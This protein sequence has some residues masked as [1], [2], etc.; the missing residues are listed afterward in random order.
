MHQSFI[1]MPHN[2]SRE[3]CVSSLW[4]GKYM[5][6]ELYVKYDISLLMGKILYFSCTI[7]CLYMYFQNC[8]LMFPYQQPRVSMSARN[9]HQNHK[10]ELIYFETHTRHK[11]HLKFGETLSITSSHFALT[12][13]QEIHIFIARLIH[14]DR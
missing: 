2:P 11:K 3:T 8:P 13:Y 14:Q 6:L 4:L 5:V 12:R 1:I 10:L 7:Y 9:K